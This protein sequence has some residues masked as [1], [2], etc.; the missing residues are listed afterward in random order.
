MRRLAVDA[1]GMR[2]KMQVRRKTFFYRIAKGVVVSTVATENV[3]RPVAAAGEKAVHAA[4]GFQ[5]E[6]VESQREG[7]H[8]CHGS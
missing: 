5:F 2:A 7:G 6:N 1:R 3:T 4:A 8:N